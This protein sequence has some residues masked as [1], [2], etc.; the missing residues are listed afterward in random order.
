MKF[1]ILVAGTNEPSNSEYL[2]DRFAEGLRAG[3]GTQIVKLRLNNLMIEHFTIERYNDAC[4]LEG[5]FCTVKDHMLSSRGVIIAT[6]IWN[7]SVPAHLKN[8][9]DRMGS[10]ALDTTRTKGQLKG[11]P[12]YCIFTGGAPSRAWVLM[13]ETT[14]HIGKAIEYFGGIHAGTYFEPSCMKGRGVFGLV[15]HER[16][17]TLT[18]VRREGKKFAEAVRAGTVHHRGNFLLR[19]GMWTENLLERWRGT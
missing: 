11:L 12:F 4:P 19:F 13:R 7:F 5:D 17:A 1:L 16:P 6:P 10:F 8:L 15:V 3:G 2:A 18:A 14:S 9:I